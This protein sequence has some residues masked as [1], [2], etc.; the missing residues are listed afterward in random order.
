MAAPT[1][2][3]LNITQSSQS[4]VVNWQSFSIMP[5]E[6]TRFIQQNSNSSVLNRITGQDPSQIFLPAD[7]GVI[8]LEDQRKV[9]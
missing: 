6:L 4:A 2:T 5:G 1:S 8:Q 9:A 7:E 3:Q